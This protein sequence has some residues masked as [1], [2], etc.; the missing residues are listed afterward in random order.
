M[1]A[2]MIPVNQVVHLS[3]KLVAGAI[4]RALFFPLFLTCLSTVGSKS[5]VIQ[6]DLYSLMV[7]FLFAVSNGLLVSTSFMWSPHLVGHTTGMQERASEIMTFSVC[8]G[9]LSGSL[10][11][12][13][14]LQ[15]A[16]RILQ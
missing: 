11:A 8:F 9:L 3:R 4:L 1:L 14:F 7:Q 5:F 10:L 15:M 13:P 16:M 6:S 12:F 2:E